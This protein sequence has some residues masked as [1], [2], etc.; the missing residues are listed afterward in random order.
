MA[1]LPAAPRPDGSTPSDS[2]LPSDVDV[3]ALLAQAE[4]LARDVTAEIGVAGD[5][6]PGAEQTNAE[7]DAETET[8]QDVTTRFEQVDALVDDA[9]EAVGAERPAPD[10]PAAAG[11]VEVGVES[12]ESASPEAAISGASPAVDIECVD[13]DGEPSEGGARAE[14][15]ADA[16]PSESAASAAGCAEAERD[17]PADMGPDAA[18]ADQSSLFIRMPLWILAYVLLVLDKPFGW[19]GLGPRRVLGAVAV[20]TFIM[21]GVAWLLPLLTGHAPASPAAGH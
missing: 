5:A 13:A 2:A 12:I 16:A 7:L 6:P 1:D 14:V 11:L 21:A 9:A 3:E 10:A 19:I 8:T 15:D 4:A 18:N 17:S 20:A